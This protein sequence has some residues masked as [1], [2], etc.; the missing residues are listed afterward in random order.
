MSDED[1]PQATPTKAAPAGPAAYVEP[2]QEQPRK[3]SGRPRNH[4]REKVVK[5]AIEPGRQDG[6]PA[7]LARG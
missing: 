3:Q 5:E 2:T 1:L 4:P 6:P 7:V